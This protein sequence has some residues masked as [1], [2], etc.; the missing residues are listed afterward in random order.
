[1]KPENFA[2]RIDAHLEEINDALSSTIQPGFSWVLEAGNLL[3]EARD[4]L[5]PPQPSQTRDTF[6]SSGEP[7]PFSVLP[8]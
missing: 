2:R 5:D 8:P 7:H 3:R 6:E 1:M 4:L